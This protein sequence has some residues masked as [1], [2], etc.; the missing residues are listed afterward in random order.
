MEAIIIGG[1]GLKRVAAA[2]AI[3]M[4]VL[5][6]TLALSA[7]VRNTIA[8]SGDGRLHYFGNIKS[9]N[10]FCW[11]G[12]KVHYSMPGKVSPLFSLFW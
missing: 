5:S 7:L 3:Q 2:A 10:K 1:P 6:C 8:E 4:E 9:H 12:L 11:W